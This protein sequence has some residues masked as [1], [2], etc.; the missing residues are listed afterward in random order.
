[1]GSL[2]YG[3]V[4]CINEHRTNV[5]IN[6]PVITGP[7]LH[8]KS[9]FLFS[10]TVPPIAPKSWIEFEFKRSLMANKKRKAKWNKERDGWFSELVSKSKRRKFTE[11][12]FGMI[13]FSKLKQRGRNAKRH[14]NNTVK[15]AKDL[16]LPS[17]LGNQFDYAITREN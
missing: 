16:S 11:K 3:R 7:I 1:M 14:S 2:N 10:H 17:A 13:K 8:L 9:S 5:R 12:A 6:S 15:N 4:N